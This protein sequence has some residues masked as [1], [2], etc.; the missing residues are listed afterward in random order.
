MALIILKSS[1]KAYTRGGPQ[2]LRYIDMA[3][4]RD[5]KSIV[6]IERWVKEAAETVA[7][8]LVA[9]AYTEAS[10]SGRGRLN[11]LVVADRLS[12]GTQRLRRTC[13]GV[14]VEL[15]VVDRGLFESD[16]KVSTLLEVAAGRLL[17]PY[18]ALAGE[19]Y[20]ARW[21]RLYKQRKIRESLTTLALEHPE[22]LSELLIDPRYFVHDSLMRLAHILPQASDLLHA[23]D[24]ERYRIIEGY[25]DALRELERE[26]AIHI[27]GYLISVDRGFVDAVLRKSASISDQRTQVQRQL[28]DL[29]KMSLSEVVDLF[30]SL[31]G[32]SI[33]EGLL[34]TVSEP[35]DLP[36]P[37]RFLHF[38]TATGLAPLSE[39]TRV[40][41]LLDWLEPSSR[42]SDAWLQRFSGVLNEVY[43]LTYTVDRRKRRAI[44]KRYP[45]WVSLKWAPIALWTLGTQNFAVLGRSRMERECAT[46]SLLRRSEIKVPT[47]LH[48]SFEDRLLLREYVEGKNLANIVRTVIRRGRPSDNEGNLLR[49]VGR[50]VADVHGVGVT[51]GDCKPENFIVTAGGDPVI[52][53]LEQ[54]A[55]GGNMTWD[56][57]EFL[58]FSGHYAGPLDPLA[59]VAETTRCFIEGYVSGGGSR[60]RVAE[61]AQLRYTKVFTPLTLPRVIYTIAKTC[62]REEV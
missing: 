46:T 45:N 28:Q 13:G 7:P 19:G 2:S 26:G 8:D 36:R 1:L 44:L 57:A 62:R 35:S 40:D 29:I 3:E 27:K 30:R 43:L 52:I 4:D 6:E 14:E 39:S 51:L 25:M 59:G 20:L 47:I 24:E 37:D 41:E 48:T 17:H 22:L 15:L 18:I 33:V 21:D 32:F 10:Y 12:G 60:R 56:L 31:P 54:G 49:R 34:S 55:R 23:L 53:D 11:A 42:V 58:Y 50:T 5:A 38:P 16:V 9:L 61:A